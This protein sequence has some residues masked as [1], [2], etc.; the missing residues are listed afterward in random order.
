MGGGRIV[1]VKIYRGALRGPRAVIHPSGQQ[2]H[3]L[4]PTTPAWAVFRKPEGQGWIFFRSVQ[5][6]L[7]STVK[8]HE[9]SKD[10]SSLVSYS[11]RLDETRREARRFASLHWR[12]ATF[13]LFELWT[14]L[15]YGVLHFTVLHEGMDQWYDHNER[16]GVSWSH[17]RTAIFDF[18]CSCRQDGL[19]RIRPPLG[20]SL[21]RELSCFIS[22]YLWLSHEIYCLLLQHAFLPSM[23]QQPFSI[24]TYLHYV[25]Q[26]KLLL[27]TLKN[28]RATS[29]GQQNRGVKML[30]K[31]G[32]AN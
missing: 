10:T 29:I 15:T 32:G 12:C 4:S 21:A 24:T 26:S 27:E 31:R 18:F 16:K 17:F 3:P 19:R 7:F 14:Y 22:W 2:G 1:A 30:R 23:I 28:H 20:S 11:R 8:R 13:L 5:I 6:E 25:R 9:Q